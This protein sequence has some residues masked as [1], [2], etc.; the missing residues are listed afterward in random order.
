MSKIGIVRDSVSVDK[1]VRLENINK[2]ETTVNKIA[3]NYTAQVNVNNSEVFILLSNP[4]PLVYTGAYIR[5]RVLKWIKDGLASNSTLTLNDYLDKIVPTQVGV[6]GGQTTGQIITAVD[7]TAACAATPNIDVA[8]EVSGG[9]DPIIG[10]GIY[11]VNG[12]TPT[13]PVAPGNYALAIDTKQYFITVNSAS[14]I[15]FI[16]ICPLLLDFVYNLANLSKPIN[17]GNPDAIAFNIA[18]GS[19]FGGPGIPTYVDYYF[20]G[21]TPSF[22][23]FGFPTTDPNDIAA[24]NVFGPTENNVFGLDNGAW[25]V[26]LINNGTTN[27]PNFAALDV[28]F[29]VKL[30]DSDVAN[31]TNAQLYISFDFNANGGVIAD[32]TFVPFQIQFS[33][34]PAFTGS[35]G[36]GIPGFGDGT[37]TFSSAMGI[38]GPPDAFTQLFRNGVYFPGGSSLIGTANFATGTFADFDPNTGIVMI[39]LQ[40]AC[41]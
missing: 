19:P 3:I 29:G 36:G 21:F 40:P 28:A 1:P 4:A 15:S 41:L 31:F 20:Q 38:P 32:S 25:P 22:G 10:T 14:N 26:G 5:E 23:G 16:E 30:A 7:S 11:L 33:Q 12:T 18:G 8:L 37:A 2:I 17:N 39:V 6:I 27:V 9:G 34:V 24:C 35:P 13:G